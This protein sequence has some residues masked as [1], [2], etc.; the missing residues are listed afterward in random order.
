MN[1]REEIFWDLKLCLLQRVSLF[2]SS[3]VGDPL[4]YRHV[5][6]GGC[7][8]GTSAY[9]S[10]F[11]ALT[12]PGRSLARQMR[13]SSCSSASSSWLLGEVLPFGVGGVS[14]TVTSA[15]IP[16]IDQYA[17]SDRTAQYII[18]DRSDQYT[19]SDRSDQY[20][21]SDRSDQYTISD[22]SDQYT[23][24]DRSDQYTISDRS[25]QYTISD[26]SDQYTISDRSDQYTISDRSD[27]YTISDRSDQYTIS[28]RSEQYVHH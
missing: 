8:W 27:Q 4:Y 20:T 10:S 14:L 16:Y 28:D 3:T 23:I 9:L 5:P 6:T 12:I 1:Y 25:D 11:I 18:S 7:S 26:R 2:Q 22:R 24:S 13:L 15:A 21:I 17:I 19:I